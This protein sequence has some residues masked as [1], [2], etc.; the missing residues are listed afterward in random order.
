VKPG[1]LII[2]PH[3][4]WAST[5]LSSVTKNFECEFVLTGKE[6]QLK[7]YK[8]EYAYVFVHMDTLH[9]SGLEVIRYI[10]NGFPLLKV[11]ALIDD[12]TL[13]DYGTDEAMLKKL[14]VSKVLTSLK[15]TEILSPIQGL[16]SLK[17][18]HDVE[19][20][21]KTGETEEAEIG[22]TKFTRIKI[23][24]LFDDTKAIFD[25]YLR[26]GTNRYI[27]IIH[28][29]E[30]S[31]SIQIKKYADSGA[32]YLY[33][34]AED[35]ADFIGYQNELASDMLKKTVIS[36]AKILKNLKTTTDK[37]IEEVFVQGIQPQLIEEGK[38][39]SHNMYEFAKKDKSLRK[40]LSSLEE[41]N[42]A[43][44]SHSFLVS[45][46]ST[47]ISKNLDWVGA[48]TL[49]ALALGALFHDIGLV[50]IPENI[51]TKKME[52]M[53]DEEQIVF[54]QHP[55]KGTESLE[56]IPSI[57]ASIQNIVLQHHETSNGSGF[58]LGLSGHKIFP[59]AKIIGLADGFSDYIMERECSP[60]DGIKEFL[61][62]RDNLARY[63]SDLVKSLV[64]GFV[65]P[66]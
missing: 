53:S 49:E 43:V 25:F 46:F 31:S 26:L 50:Q 28:K 3:E 21:E 24:D 2:S 7:I 23:E 48:R 58:P 11:F 20:P 17:K 34:L 32:K 8:Q 5:A 19:A 12:K 1:I 6:G 38:A 41:F 27:K 57:T 14:G 55:K 22:D 9:N 64:K 66:K 51:A 56:G 40:V 30:T 33:F 45:F 10:H 60:L 16:G 44:Y 39:I 42:P 62:E 13:A 37:Y 15:A 4:E 61:N 47:V 18:W 29:G 65:A 54:K 35:R 63:D 36:E 59:L 52:D